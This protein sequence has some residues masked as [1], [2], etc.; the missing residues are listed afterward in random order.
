MQLAQACERAHEFFKLLHP[1]E[2]K[3]YDFIPSLL[4]KKYRYRFLFCTKEGSHLMRR[5]SMFMSKQL[6]TGLILVAL[7]LAAASRA[8]AEEKE[9]DWKAACAQ[10][11]DIAVPAGDRPSPEEAKSLKDC[12]SEDLYYGIT[13]P[14]DP[15]KARK[16]AYVELDQ[17]DEK[18]FGGSSMLM[19]IYANGRGA[20]RNFDLAIK[21]ACSLEGAPAE[22][23]GRIENLTGKKKTGW[24]G[25]NFSLC[26]DITSGFM[27][28][29]CEAHRERFKEAE[30]KRKTEALIAN[31]SGA[32][33]KAFERLRKAADAY[34][35]LRSDAE[36][37]LSGT[38]R[39]A[40]EIEERRSL[41]NDFLAL[42]ES[43][44]RGKFLFSSK[45]QLAQADGKLNAVYQR[46]QKNPDFAYGTVTRE[47]I[48]KTQRAWIAYR[49][50]WVAFAAGKYTA[51]SPESIKTRLTQKRTKMLTEFVN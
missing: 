23:E 50:A 11:K 8:T 15:E 33:R 51:V 9:F 12:S 21:F 47:G 27:E 20:N 44:E 42:I 39:G 45:K 25:N 46:I 30:R 1:T 34:F 28:G 29:H 49:D 10:V 3:F 17:G 36:V 22:M 14:A 37:D 13:R 48:K 43:L 4:E 31:W 16:C 5:I 40:F 32:D 18:V 19:T 41:E 6:A 2:K 26:D 24:K 35:G 7:I 38:G